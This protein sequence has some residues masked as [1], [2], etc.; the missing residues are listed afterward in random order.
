MDDG[1]GRLWHG[2]TC[3]A[4]D[5]LTLFARDY[6]P[7]SDAP[8]APA[9]P[10]VCLPGLA[11]HSADFHEVALALSRDAPRKR[12]VLAVDYRGRGRSGRDRTWENYTVQTETTDLLTLLSVAGIGRA[13]FLGT[14]RGGLI[15]M[16]LS[17]MRPAAI[18]GAILNDIGPVIDGQGL[19][20]IR[21]YVGKM[22]TP[23][24]WD[25]A[26]DMLKTHAHRRFPAL[27]DRE[28][29]KF[30]E[31]TWNMA[32]GKLAPSYDPALA[33]G[34]Q[35]LDL[36]RPLPALWEP[37]LGLSGVPILAIRGENSDLLSA[38]ILAE[39]ARRHPACETLVVEGQGH[40]PLLDDAP[41][42]MAITRFCARLDA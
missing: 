42:L 32:D 26:V 31:R 21:Q 22:G 27:S 19:A 38:E 3:S 6:M 16:M 36:E 12:R 40:A 10:V 30:A 39:M 15:A 24:D 33:K 41:S 7:A 28:W 1:E 5:G 14:S 20:R 18:A 11:R 34:L 35:A 13:I 9:L 2:L 29:R 23:A 8:T 4:Q 37:F 25:D 17:A